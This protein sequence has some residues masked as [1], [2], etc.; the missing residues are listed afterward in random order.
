MHWTERDRKRNS[1]SSGLFMSKAANCSMFFFTHL[2]LSLNSACKGRA[3]KM[4]GQKNYCRKNFWIFLIH[5]FVCADVDEQ[6]G[7]R[8]G[9]RMLLL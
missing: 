4:S 9:F 7:F 5:F 1:V 8:A 2:Y 6:Q 3:R